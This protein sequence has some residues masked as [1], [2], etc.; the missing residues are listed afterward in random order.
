MRTGTNKRKVK[1]VRDQ[2][3]SVLVRVSVYISPQPHLY[4][5]CFLVEKSHAQESSLQNLAARENLPGGF[6]MDGSH[7]DFRLHITLL[8]VSGT[9]IYTAQ[10]DD[11]RCRNRTPW[12]RPRRSGCSSFNRSWQRPGL[13]R[14][15]ASCRHLIF[16]SRRRLSPG[17]S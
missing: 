11:R 5:G 2:I 8:A 16:K 3:S 10:R 7:S 9:N 15:I 6:L 14:I 1:M 4:C 13:G 17:A 12:S